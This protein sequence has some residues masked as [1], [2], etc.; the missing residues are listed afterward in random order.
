MD[1]IQINR[2][3][4]IYSIDGLDFLLML[5]EP[6]RV[7]VVL[8]DNI[9]HKLSVGQSLVFRRYV[10]DHSDR[11]IVLS[12]TVE[13]LEKTTYNGHDAVYVSVPQVE[14]LRVPAW[15]ASEISFKPTYDDCFEDY[16]GYF[17]D[18][19]RYLKVMDGDT[20]NINDWLYYYNNGREEFFILEFASD[21]HIFEQDIEFAE[22]VLN[23]P[24]TID[25][26]TE[27][28][29]KIGSFGGI[30]IPFNGMPMTV[31]SSD[32]LTKTTIDACGY[33][34]DINEYKYTYLPYLFS[35]RRIKFTTVT[36]N[37][38]EGEFFDKVCYLINHGTFF[39]PNYNTFYYYTM[40]GSNKKC[41]LWH[42]IWW[43]AYDELNSI[44]PV[45]DI[46]VN[47]GNSRCV[48]G[49]END[50]WVI[51]TLAISS[52]MYNL[53]IEEGQ[54]N[55]YV[56]SIIDGVIPEVI[57]MERFKYSPVVM[58]NRKYELARSIT[59][60]MHF[61]RRTSIMDIEGVAAENGSYPIYDK[62]WYINED[63]AN[64]IWWNGMGTTD[65]EGKYT[66][67]DF[68]AFNSQAFTDFYNASGESADLLGY[69][70]FS[71]EDVYY[72]KSKLS[73][74][75]IRLSFYTS[76][77]PVS[78]KLLYY[79]TSFLDATSL[80]GKFMKQSML[81]YD[82]YGEF[83]TT[84]VVFFPDNSASAR[85]DCEIH[86]ENEFNNLA[87]S[88]GFNLYLFG[89]DA[90]IKD[91]GKNYRTIY[92]KVE[93]NH[94]GN[95]KTIPMVMWPR[96]N[97]GYREISVDTFI[98]DLY[99]P[100]QI[101]YDN[102]R[103]VYTLP[104]AVNDNGNLRLI[105]FEPK[106]DYNE[107]GTLQE[108]YVPSAEYN[109]R[110]A[111][112]PT[113]TNPTPRGSWR[114]DGT[115][116]YD[117]GIGGETVE[118]QQAE[119][120]SGNT[121]SDG[122]EPEGVYRTYFWGNISTMPKRAARPATETLGRAILVRS[123]ETVTMNVNVNS[124][125][126]ENY[127]IFWKGVNQGAGIGFSDGKPPLGSTSATLIARRKQPSN[128]NLRLIKNGDVNDIFW[129]ENI[130]LSYDDTPLTDE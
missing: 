127:Q 123:G 110:T 96:G 53:G 108:T 87:S 126:K 93:F 120:D 45:K 22:N 31:T 86:I 12:T 98:N 32:T 15:F 42:D 1:A 83:E 49:V 30:S 29:A 34:Y 25:V 128:L 64:T 129:A 84:P 77:D 75:F 56:D 117:G 27:G 74:S 26:L 6:D 66:N 79:S 46:Y 44:K 38:A 101:M 5:E 28:G 11:P 47:S 102:G 112:I 41:E 107:G 37:Q 106:L 8:K 103:F 68:Y 19:Q 91:K 40:D 17:D 54:H 10:Y 9:N 97:G 89:D 62:G 3:K 35:R 92:M 18:T 14:N 76:K 130:T 36:T 85:V 24:F 94:A 48:F 55:D 7:L 73:M 121:P 105:L 88:E 69:L 114:V 82:K 99:I 61:R 60:D 109:P 122:S 80:F 70:G 4:K 95:G 33:E 113:E 124:P 57:D 90:D 100:V 119:I 81:K 23:A 71:D 2:N 67:H 43:E 39:V 111:D 78:Q 118:P 13:L 16:D 125:Y 63:S 58:K 52:D 21:H 115:E 59:I 50:Y 104:T 65:S 51:P 20:F 72:R 116:E